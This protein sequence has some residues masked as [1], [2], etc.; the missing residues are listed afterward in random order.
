MS[1]LEDK[2]GI[3]KISGNFIAASYKSSVNRNNSTSNIDNFLLSGD[4]QNFLKKIDGLK[5]VPSNE[6]KSIHK[7][8]PIEERLFDAT[9]EIKMLT[10]TVGMYLTKKWRDK[11]FSQIDSLHSFS[12]WDIDGNP[13][14]KESFQTFLKTIINLNPVDFPALGLADNGF[15]LAGWYEGKDRLTI[16]FHPKDIVKW[17]V[18]KDLGSEIER[19]N[20]V[21]TV[22][23]L[24]AC[25]LPYNQKSW[26][27]EKDSQPR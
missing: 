23:R 3:K 15:L 7:K 18:S 4:T 19:A 5:V 26:F 17:I 16:E 9:A 21:T 6:I 13:I 2:K 14:Q 24:R 1:Q 10:S 25:L 20:G 27:N 11:V 12:D 8:I 22:S